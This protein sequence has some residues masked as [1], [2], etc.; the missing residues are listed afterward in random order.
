MARSI[1]TG[2]KA[3]AQPWI[4]RHGD[5]PRG[6][7][8]STLIRSTVLGQDRSITVYTPPGFQ[9]VGTGASRA[10]LPLPL[11]VLFDG[12]PFTSDRF[13]PTP[14][15]IDNLIAAGRIQP[16]VAVFVANG[17][18]RMKELG[19]DSLFS[20]FVA[21]EV[22]PWVQS[23]YGVTVAPRTTVIGGSSHGGL[24]ATCTAMRFPKA[25]G[26]VISQSGSYWW[27]PAPTG[28]DEWVTS[29]LANRPPLPIRFYLEVG[30]F[31]TDRSPD[32]GPGQVATNRHLRDVLR[33]RGYDVMYAEFPG[34]HEYFNW[35]GTLSTALVHF[36]PRAR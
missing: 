5:V 12:G 2:P 25:F 18:A 28:E 35:R 17:A 20:S 26:N 22:L 33:A 9:P 32:G 19:C 34:A 29:E 24:G 21:T 7:L 30:I 36:L 4:E 27:K 11:L 1:V 16:L 23:R 14:T 6:R 31:E 15:I 8:D 10:P 13:V 3:A